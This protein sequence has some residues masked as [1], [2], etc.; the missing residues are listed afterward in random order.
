VTG[1]T[2]AWITGGFTV[3]GVIMELGEFGTEYRAMI[4]F[5][6]YVGCRPGELFA[7]RRE[8]LRGQQ[9]TIERTVNN[10]NEVGPTKNG[11]SR[12]V[13]IPPKAHDALGDVPHHRSGLVFT[14]PQDCRWKKKRPLTGAGGCKQDRCPIPRLRSISGPVRDQAGPELCPQVQLAPTNGLQDPLPSASSGVA[15]AT[16][17]RA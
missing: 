7:L 6:G 9:C 1:E 16:A 3:V 17:N 8:D 4:L 5:A 12:T 14:S 11:R 15:T 13:V 2:T 10:L